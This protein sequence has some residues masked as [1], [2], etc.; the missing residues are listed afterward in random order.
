[1]G[2]IELEEEWGGDAPGR[3]ASTDG[4]QGCR[5]GGYFFAGRREGGGGI[6][7]SG[8]GPGVREAAA[9]SSRG[10][11]RRPPQPAGTGSGG[12]GVGHGGRESNRMRMLA[13]G[14][15]TW[16]WLA[17]FGQREPAG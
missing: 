10:R 12:G 13:R 15:H 5:G 16:H 14:A 1:M 3:P 4:V 17:K 11:L 6:G 7:R 9:L 8:G 2:G